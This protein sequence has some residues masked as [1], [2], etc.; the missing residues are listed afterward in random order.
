MRT[1]LDRIDPADTANFE[2]KHDVAEELERLRQRIRSL[3]ARLFAE[4][5]RALLV[6]LQGMDTSGKDGAVRSVFA[7]LDPHAARAWSFKAPTA[8]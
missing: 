6:V 2:S 8:D 3:Q 7:A 4:R 1:R 5:Q